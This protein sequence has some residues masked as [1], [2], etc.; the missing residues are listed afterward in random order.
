MAAVTTGYVEKS[1]NWPKSTEAFIPCI[2]NAVTWIF[3]NPS[4]LF[5][6]RDGVCLL[7]EIRELKESILQ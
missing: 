1:I 5:C 3:I 2:T 6:P 7:S 4:A